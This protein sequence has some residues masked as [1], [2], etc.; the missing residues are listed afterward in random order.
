MKKRTLGI[1]SITSNGKTYY[2][3]QRDV[4]FIPKDATVVW[5]AEDHV[6]LFY[7]TYPADWAG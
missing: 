6:K 1:L 7:S 3:S 2:A 4:L 5:N